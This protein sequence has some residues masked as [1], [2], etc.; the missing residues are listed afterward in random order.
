MQ[1]PHLTPSRGGH[2]SI[3]TQRC[4]ACTNCRAQ[5]FL[6]HV[7][8]APTCSHAL[9][10][11]QDPEIIRHRQFEQIDTTFYG[12]VSSLGVAGRLCAAVS[13]GAVP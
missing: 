11:A 10:C 6:L 1:V 12:L 2:A 4:V 7:A 3:S 13:W 9:C 8:L 5:P